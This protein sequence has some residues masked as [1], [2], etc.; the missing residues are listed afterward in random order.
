MAPPML[1]LPQDCA[2]SD[3]GCSLLGR[4]AVVLARS[5]RQIAQRVLLGELAEAAEVRR[6][7]LRISSSGRQRHEP[8][9]VVI[10]HDQL[11]Q[12]FW[13]IARC[14]IIVVLIPLTGNST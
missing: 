5:D 10:G 14:R 2:D 12:C 9:D 6:G 1:A 4:Y 3:E 7:T 11:R 8:A 13:R